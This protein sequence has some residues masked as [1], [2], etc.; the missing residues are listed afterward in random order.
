MVFATCTLFLALFDSE[1]TK[2]KKKKSPQRK[3]PN[4]SEYSVSPSFDN[5]SKIKLLIIRFTLQESMIKLL[6]ITLVDAFNRAF[7]CH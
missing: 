2:K 7:P 5:S 4:S 3:N 6:V 1:I